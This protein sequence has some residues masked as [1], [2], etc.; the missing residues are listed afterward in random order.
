MGSAFSYSDMSSTQT[1]D[2]KHTYLRSEPCPN[3]TK[4]T[5]LVIESVPQAEGAKQRTA[6]SKTV[7]WVR[8]D[9]WHVAQAE[10]FDKDGALWKRSVSSDFREVDAAAHKVLAHQVRIDDLKAKKF[11]ILA[12]QDAK[13]TTPVPDSTFT[14]QNLA[15]E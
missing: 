15:R 2:Y 7:G 3:D 10:C 1:D 14:Q 8:N 12:F 13:T 6:Y 11:S 9:N 4:V 5:C